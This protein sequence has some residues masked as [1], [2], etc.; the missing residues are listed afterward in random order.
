MDAL[1]GGKVGRKERANAL[2][3]GIREGFPV[4]LSKGRAN[5]QRKRN[6]GALLD[7]EQSRKFSQEAVFSI[8]IAAMAGIWHTATRMRPSYRPPALCII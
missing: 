8:E 4:P 1:L 7:R 5:H 2:P 6:T 3:F